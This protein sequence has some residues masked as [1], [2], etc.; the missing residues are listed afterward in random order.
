MYIAEI[1]INHKGSEEVANQM[2]SSVLNTKVDAV[3]FQVLSKDFYK[4]NKDYG[5]QL[6]PEFYIQ[7]IKDTHNKGKLIG[8]SIDSLEWIPLLFDSC[9]D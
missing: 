9:A 6:S 7:A 8:F 1:G 3:T 4:N 2:L 5:D